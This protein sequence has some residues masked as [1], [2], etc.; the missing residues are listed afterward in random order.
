MKD[1]H[2]SNALFVLFAKIYIIGVVCLP[3]RYTEGRQK[4]KFGFKKCFV[5]RFIPL[6]WCPN[7]NL[8][9]VDVIHFIL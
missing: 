9:N 3:N 2:I 8:I 5:E 4:D 7:L 6:A 1:Y